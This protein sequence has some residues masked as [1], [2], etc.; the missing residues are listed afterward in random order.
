MESDSRVL[1]QLRQSVS[2]ARDSSRRSR[3]QGGQVLIEYILLLVITT[4]IA[5][6]LV[7]ALAS[8]SEDSPGLIIEKWKKVGEEIGKDLPE[9]CVGEPCSR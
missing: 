6:I 3:R 7:K 8:R 4:G 9:K 5:A 1:V 2:P